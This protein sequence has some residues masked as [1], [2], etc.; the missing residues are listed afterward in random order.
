[1]HSKNKLFLLIFTVLIFAGLSY[2]KAELTVKGGVMASEFT[3]YGAG[4]IA[5][6]FAPESIPLAVEL[7][8]MGLGYNYLETV[9]PF[10]NLRFD[11]D[12]GSLFTIYPIA[13]VGCNPYYYTGSP[14]GYT[15]GFA[16]KAGGG[17]MINIT[18]FLSIRA[19]AT[20]MHIENE[21]RQTIGWYAGQFFNEVGFVTG[22]AGL[23]AKF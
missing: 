21:W 22:T 13:G 20:Y 9:I 18:K 14:A 10:V 6:G 3:T 12:L 8:A 23:T 16:A 2:A 19:E 7:S 1:M 17:A 4:E 15:M 5:I 11:I